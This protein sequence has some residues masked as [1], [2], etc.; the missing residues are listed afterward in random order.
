MCGN[1]LQV[2][3][4]EIKRFK[5]KQTHTM[6]TPQERISRTVGYTLK[7]GFFNP[8]SPNLPMRIA[9]LAEANTANQT[10]IDWDEPKE[11]TS[12]QQA[13]NIYGFGSPIHILYNILR[14]AT[15][16]L[17]GSIPT[18]VYPQEEAGSAA[19]KEI[20]VTVT[21]TATRNG[22]QTVVIAGR[23]G[24]NG[25]RYDINIESG[26]TAT[27][28]AVKIKNAVNA[29]LG[30]PMSADNTDGVVTL[31]SK[32][33]GLTADDLQV[34]VNTND[35]STGMSYAVA[36]S[37]SGSGTPAVTTALTNFGDQWNT[38]VV[39]S[40]GTVSAVLSA[41][42]AHNGIADPD[43]PTGRYQATVWKPYIALTGSVS[44]DPSATTDAKKNEMTV[45]LC[46]APGSKALPMEAAANV[47]VLLARQTQDSP[48]STVH[49]KLYP[50]MPA[51][52]SIGTMGTSDN[53]DIIVKKGCSTVSL[54][55]GK[56]KIQD[57]VT[58]YHPA[59]EIPPAYRYVRDMYLHMNVRYGHLLLQQQYVVDH[60]IVADNSDVDV[61]K[62]VK[63][64]MWRSILSEY[65][66]DLA[67]RG[68]IAVATTMQQS[69]QVSISQANPARLNDSYDYQITSTANVADSV[70][71][72][73]FYYG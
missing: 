64:K 23:E 68:L 65:A 66:L 28:V 9:I 73:G 12:A 11:I 61:D 30:S 25:E 70:V 63:P 43:L 50:D 3:K 32:W 49:G 10:G 22:T 42:E 4:Q 72:G 36:S 18:V 15:G 53:R 46:V 21:G 31:T 55:N 29:V 34:S 47:A 38:I 56:Y 2:Y 44:D 54:D 14:P 8:S 51:P 16:G 20:T 13:G 52:A 40:Y 60:T 71:T 1:S 27:E 24:V 7:K 33:A 58:T 39:N 6:A 67:S 41:L 17:L 59:G 5:T 26:D 69:I 35:I 45:A 19:A 57:L 48:H 62:I 37:Q